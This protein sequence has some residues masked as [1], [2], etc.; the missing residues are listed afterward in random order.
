MTSPTEITGRILMRAPLRYIVR[1]LVVSWQYVFKSRTSPGL[2]AAVGR[3]RMRR[4]D[5]ATRLPNSVPGRADDSWRSAMRRA[6][7][8]NAQ[9][10][11][12]RRSR[13]LRNDDACGI[14]RSDRPNLVLYPLDNL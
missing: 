11:S 10:F 4:G 1:S 13:H 8:S 3:W 7:A 9:R 12:A 14:R 6:S 5:L 2:F